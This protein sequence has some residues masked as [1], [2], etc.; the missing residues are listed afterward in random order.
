VLIDDLRIRQLLTVDPETRIRD[1]MDDQFVALNVLDDEESAVAV[2]R[3][4]DRSVLPVVDTSGVLVGIVTVDDVLDLLEREA[5]EDIQKLGGAG[6]RGAVP[7]R[8]HLDHGAQAR[9][10]AGHPALRR[11]AHGRG[12]V[13]LRGR[14]RRAPWCSRSS[15]R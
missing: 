14:A 2:F 12:H 6:A 1:L 9:D 15:C 8:A 13:V 11:D 3:K 10:V 7:R 4:H 5:T